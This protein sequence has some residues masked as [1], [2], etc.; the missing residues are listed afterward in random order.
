MSANPFFETWDAPFGAPPFARI[1]PE[2]FRP[3][4][5]RALA[6]HAREIA[7]VA[8]D[9]QA[10]SF[11]NTIVALEKSGRLL[12]RVELVF[13]NLA[14]SHTNDELEA[15]ELEMAPVLARHW[16]AIY[17]NAALFRRI[18][19]L[20]AR[21]DAL[22]LD[23]QE[24]RVLE[25]YHLDFLRAGARLEG[26]ERARL[27]QI[28]ERLATLAT[29]FAQNVLADEQ[30][31]ILPMAEADLEGLPS[32]ARE[33]AAGIARERK[34]DAPFA[35]TTSRS[36]AEVFLQFAERRDLRE[37]VFKAWISRGERA[38]NPLI[39]E[40]VRLKAEKARLLGYATYA[41]Y[42]LADTMA[43]TPENARMLLDSV[44]IPARAR[45]L[46]ERDALQA[47][48]AE[49]GSNAPLAAWDWRYYAEKL[50]KQRYDFDEA[51]II[52]YLELERMIAAAFYTAGRLFGLQFAERSDI[53]VYHPDVRVW[54]VTRDGRHVGLFFGDYFARASKRGGAWMSSFR[55]SEDIDGRIAPIIVNTCNFPKTSPALLNFDEAKTLF[56][57]FGHALHGLLSDVRFPRIAGTHVAQDFVE[58]PSQIFEHW[59]EE[60]AVLERFAR[61]VETGAPMPKALLEKLMAARNFNQGFQNVEFLASAIADLDFHSLENPQ[62]VDPAAEEKKTLARIGMPDE[63]VMRHRPAHFLHVFGGDGY[64]AGYYSYLWAA[65]LDTDGFGAFREAG[66][67]F[68][69]ATAKRLHDFV[70]AA[71]GT[72]DYAQAYRAFRGRD[73]D[74][75]ALLEDRGL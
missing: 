1:R 51:E 53:P 8:E 5:E 44:W 17:L 19:D 47:V 33:A 31:A 52:P 37:K 72:R 68:D 24:L 34:L 10:P 35:V 41:D 15:I 26:E 11:A 39:A 2:H 40:T 16:N 48:A 36:S 43:K 7:D 54:A 55:D 3:A 21:R 67:V 30:D 18:D 25:R 57:E 23:A 62:A 75:A 20:Y 70:Y 59:L 50:R 9:A 13:S 66:D 6:D 64:A 22:G 45:A 56:H 42:K 58:L 12:S 69:G 73:P 32:F 28:G 65:V 74:I 27:A 46:D 71:G 14:S 38:N 4:Y 49:E 63:I 29:E 61:H 60:P